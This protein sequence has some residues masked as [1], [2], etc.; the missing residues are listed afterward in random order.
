MP[1]K[2]IFIEALEQRIMLDGAGA[3][4]FMDVVEESNKEKLPLKSSKEIA[5][6]KEIRSVDNNNDLPFANVTRDKVRKKQIVFIDTQISDYQTLIDSF[7]KNTKVVLIEANEDGFKKIEQSLKGEKSIL[8]FILLVM[9][10]QDKFYLE[11]HSSLM[12]I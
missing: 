6:F 8:L 3:S 10:V 4:T 9:V 12:R 1:K 7:D 5:K 2:K 11:T